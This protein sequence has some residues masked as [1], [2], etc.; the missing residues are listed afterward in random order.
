MA[1]VHNVNT[2]VV[3]WTE[4]GIMVWFTSMHPAAAAAA[5]VHVDTLTTYLLEFNYIFFFSSH[6]SC[7][8]N[9]DAVSLL[10]LLLF[11][12]FPEWNRFRKRSTDSLPYVIESAA[13]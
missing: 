8:P 2:N 12:F 7:M 10:L 4:R 5:A 3:I 11:W 1:N 9:R 6:M 13:S